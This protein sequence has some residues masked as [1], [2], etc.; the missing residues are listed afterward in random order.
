MLVYW[1]VLGTGREIDLTMTK[2]AAYVTWVTFQQNE[3][4]QVT[5]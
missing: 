1:L 4:L 2:Q 5:A 3:S